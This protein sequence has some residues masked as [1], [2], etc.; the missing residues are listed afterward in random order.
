MGSQTQLG[1]Y[2]EKEDGIST[3]KPPQIVTIRRCCKTLEMNNIQFTANNKTGS[4]F[5]FK[6]VGFCALDVNLVS[7][8][9]QLN[10]LITSDDRGLVKVN[11][12]SRA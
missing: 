10:R 11:P 2:S 12:Y 1:T 7:D 8:H 4:I 6:N 9:T 5:P 3:D